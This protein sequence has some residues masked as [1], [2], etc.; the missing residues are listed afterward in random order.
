MH[1]YLSW[2]GEFEGKKSRWPNKRVCSHC[3]AEASVVYVY[4]NG[5]A[6]YCSEECLL[7]HFTV[8]EWN[9]YV[10]RAESPDALEPGLAYVADYSDRRW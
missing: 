2:L 9:E 5:R 3:G 10:D 6:F 1:C 8:E 7:Q 4:D